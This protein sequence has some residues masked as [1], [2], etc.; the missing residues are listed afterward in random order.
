M[1][2]NPGPPPVSRAVAITGPS[3][4]AAQTYQAIQDTLK[5]NRGAEVA[6]I[7]AMFGGDKDLMNRFL[8]V[9]FSALAKDSDLLEKATPA[10]I[11]QSIKDAAVMGLEP[12]GL[13]GEGAILV[14]GSTA[15][16]QPMWRGYLKRIRNSRK[17][18]DIDCQIV[19]LNDEFS[20]R[21]GTDPSIHHVPLLFGEKDEDSGEFLEQRGGYR[22]AYAWALMPS[23]KYLIDYMPEV[24][25]LEVRDKFSRGYQNRPGSSPWTTA[26]G[27]MYRKTVIRRLAK[28]LPGEAVDM[29]L[30]A[31]AQADAA[32]DAL[33]AAT[34]EANKAS[35]GLRSIALRAVGQLPAEAG[36][37]ESGEEQGGSETEGEAPPPADPPTAVGTG[38]PEDVCGGQ[39]PYGD[40]Q[41][42][43]LAAGHPTTVN[44]KGADGS[45][46]N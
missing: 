7:K 39:S 20:Y 13:L 17:V 16:F 40:D 43:V 6:A 3:A 9:A 41:T 18:V 32:A 36:Q 37:T 46:W 42:C 33:K 34:V 8:A 10:S 24:D 19:Y 31:D 38:G 45:T 44:H 21:L 11:I 12:T 27:E 14:Y 25:L 35:E 23:G 5:D 4:K 2:Q 15:Q 30:L 22:G 1:S 29:L 28:R 26:P